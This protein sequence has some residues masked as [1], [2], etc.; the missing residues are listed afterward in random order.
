[1]ASTDFLLP[2]DKSAWGDQGY[3]DTSR[4][5]SNASAHP[6]MQVIDGMNQLQAGKE[7]EPENHGVNE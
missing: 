5:D 3:F 4:K 6:Q 1:M 2:T 7:P